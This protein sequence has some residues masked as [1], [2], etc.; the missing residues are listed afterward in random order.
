MPEGRSMS[1]I[2]HFCGRLGVFALAAMMAAACSSTS[3]TASHDV[4]SSASAAGTTAA[5]AAAAHG[6]E[7]PLGA[8]PWSQVGPGW[9]LSLWSPVA[10]AHPGSPPP[11]GEPTYETSATTV[12]LLDPAGGRYPV[13]TFPPPGQDKSS[14]ELAGWSGD[15]SRALFYAPS[16]TPP[17][18]IIVDLHTGKQT[19][20]PVPGRP[21]FTRPDGKALLVLEDNGIP[22][23]LARV[24]L[25]GKPQ[26]TYPTA[27]NA[28]NGEY[29]ST[30]DGT[31]LVL[32]TA[33]DLVLMGNDGTVGS[34]LAIP[35]QSHCRPLRWW[36]GIAGTT[37]LASCDVSTG[38]SRLWRVPINGGAPQAL[39][40]PNTGGNG[41]DLG[42]MNA[43][44][45]PAG[46]F[47]Q[48]SGACG[49]EFLAKLNAD[50]TTSP[51][52]VPEVNKDSSVR[53]IGV[54]GAGIDLQA[55]ISCGPGQ[56]LLRYDPAANTSTVLLGPP[57]NG[58]GVIATIPYPG[59]E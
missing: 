55:E 59:Q 12:Y 32:G 35:G 43:W 56:S 46:T 34:R 30:P 19:T 6:A 54:D 3:S 5:Q 21:R 31:R 25:S 33:T 57:V 18:A 51:V 15:G 41:P 16:S 50:G 38:G 52:S 40:A 24:D 37:V 9:T 4:S 28:F 44:Q 11:P 58:G 26:L 7:A 14:P 10:A 49:S 48:A 22:P 45:L 13:I 23:G 29:L 42:D 27:G 8:V 20:I 53:V 17:S 47:V 1:V 2:G 36:D 39:T